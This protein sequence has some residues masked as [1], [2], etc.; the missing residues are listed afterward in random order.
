MGNLKKFGGLL[1]F[2]TRNP[3]VLFNY[4]YLKKKGIE[5]GYGAW[6][7]GWVDV[8]LAGESHVRIGKRVFIPRTIELRG[9]DRGKMIIGD[10]VMIDSGARLHV[11]NDATLD[12][13]NR[14]NIGPY[15][16][17]NA[18]DDLK[19]GDETML[20]PF[21]NINCADHGMEK[22]LPMRDQFGTYAPVSI[23]RDCWLGSMVVILKGVNIGDG[24]VI[25]AGS[26]V[27]S[28]IPEYAVAVGAPAKVVKER[29]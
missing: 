9:N 17:L 19:I 4:W 10:Q 6:I 16:F 25:G 15:N 29:T 1:E 20:G 8:A 24:A 13:G 7:S 11:A 21:V 14:V 3:K 18:F 12:I 26:V 2:A 5:I 23:G 22:G 28:D 27:T